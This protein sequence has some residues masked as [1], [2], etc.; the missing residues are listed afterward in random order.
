MTSATCNPPE[1]GLHFHEGAVDHILRAGD[2][3]E[4][5]GPASV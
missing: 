1:A 2:C 4:L 5:G 3:L